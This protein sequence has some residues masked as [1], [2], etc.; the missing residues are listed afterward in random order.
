[1]T[2]FFGQ[3]P[4]LLTLLRIAAAPVLILLLQS[5][6]FEAALIL[7]IVAGITD[8]LDGWIAKRFNC[9]TELGARLDP[10]A[11][12]IL[13]ISAYCM[14]AWLELIPFELVLLVIFRDLVIVGGYLVLSVDDDIPMQPSMISKINTLLQ[15]TF[16][17]AVLV[18]NTPWMQPGLIGDL[19]MLL[20]AIS[21][22]VSGVQYV[23]V[24]AIR[25][26]YKNAA[27]SDS[28]Q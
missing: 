16:V 22:I 27:E 20:V 14:L 24:W 7:F 9:V 6:D 12:K 3:I 23:W 2:A 13:I 25:R 28:N 15:I 19:L 18:E 11:D 17:I 21:T 26:S 4:N 1:M 10:L 8:S 5:E